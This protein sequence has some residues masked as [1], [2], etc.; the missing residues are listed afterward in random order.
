MMCIF[1]SVYLF[2]MSGKDCLAFFT[3]NIFYHRPSGNGV[4][5]FLQKL[6][7]LYLLPSP[8]CLGHGCTC[9][10][11]C[12]NGRLCGR[13]SSA[14]GE[15]NNILSLLPIFINITSP[16]LSRCLLVAIVI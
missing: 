14:R 4:Q 15:G 7:Y 16:I 1:F 9:F 5:Y 8:S 11:N 13:S 10:S 6:L 2:F 12:S 3:F